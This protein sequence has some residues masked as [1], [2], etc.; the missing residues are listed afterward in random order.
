MAQ[1]SMWK[2]SYKGWCK[3]RCHKI[4]NKIYTGGHVIATDRVKDSRCKSLKGDDIASQKPVNMRTVLGESK[5]HKF[6]C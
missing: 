5:F 6:N 1:K 4:E 3:D 2:E